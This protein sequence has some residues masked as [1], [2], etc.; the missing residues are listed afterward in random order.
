MSSSP[1]PGTP[2]SVP[3]DPARL[4][5]APA[6]DP[7]RELAAAMGDGWWVLGS[8]KRRCPVLPLLERLPRGSGA[9]GS[10]G[11]CNWDGGKGS[12]VLQGTGKANYT[13]FPGRLC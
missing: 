7:G 10:A 11:S 9:V 6:R 5:R 3:R 8:S 12:P 4:S 13:L 2:L 1:P